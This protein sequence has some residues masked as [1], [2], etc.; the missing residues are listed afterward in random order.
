MEDRRTINAPLRLST[1]FMC[2]S[3]AAASC[4]QLRVSGHVFSSHWCNHRIATMRDR[5]APDPVLIAEDP[6]TDST[7]LSFDLTRFNVIWSTPRHAIHKLTMRKTV[8]EGK[9]TRDLYLNANVFINWILSRCRTKEYHV[10]TVEVARGKLIT[11]MDYI[12]VNLGLT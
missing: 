1:A 9:S 11:S 7:T 2:V 3:L 5:H 8:G 12:L 6:T 10:V 4:S